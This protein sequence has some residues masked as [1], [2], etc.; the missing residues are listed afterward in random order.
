MISRL[1]PTLSAPARKG[2]H[3]SYPELPPDAPEYTLLAPWPRPLPLSRARTRVIVKYLYNSIFFEARALC[4]PSMS[5]SG[6][7]RG[8]GRG[9]R[10]RLHEMQQAPQ[11]DRFTLIPISCMDLLHACPRTTHLVYRLLRQP[12]GDTQPGAGTPEGAGRGDTGTS[13]T[14]TGASSVP[15]K[16]LVTVSSCL[17]CIASLRGLR[18]VCV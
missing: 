8:G 4:K 6:T 14:L 5:R 12:H 18:H 7:A 13:R 16:A 10:K 17:S 1:T 9:Q 3:P 2:R 15:Q 11:V